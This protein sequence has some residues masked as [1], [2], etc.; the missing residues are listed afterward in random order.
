MNYL[1]NSCKFS[2]KFI[3]NAYKNLDLKKL[4]SYEFMAF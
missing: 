2:L 1:R 4:S 3:Q